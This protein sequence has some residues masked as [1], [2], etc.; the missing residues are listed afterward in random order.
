MVKKMKNKLNTQCAYALSVTEMK[1][2]STDLGLDSTGTM[3]V[4]YWDGEKLLSE[5]KSAFF[6]KKSIGQD[7]YF[8]LVSIV[9]DNFLSA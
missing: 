3:A 5:V 4:S 2:I 9:A 6:N 7:V 8:D 1:K